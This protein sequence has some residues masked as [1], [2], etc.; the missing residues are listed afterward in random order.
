MK[1]G[2]SGGHR[3]NID[4][5]LVNRMISTLKDSY[6][7]FSLDFNEFLHLFF[8]AFFLLFRIILFGQVLHERQSR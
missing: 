3:T 2:I 7:L 8:L 1:E 5:G 6:L 4:L